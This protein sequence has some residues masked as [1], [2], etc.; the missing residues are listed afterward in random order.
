MRLKIEYK[1]LV[2][3]SFIILTLTIHIF[4]IYSKAQTTERLHLN[5][6]GFCDIEVGYDVRVGG[7]Y[8]YVT[9]NDG[10]MIINISNPS[11]PE[12]IGE[13][14]SGGAIGVSVESNLVYIASVTNGL[15]IADVSD[16][17][18]P[19]I[20]GQYTAGG[21]AYRVTISG[22]YAYVCYFDNGFKILNISD[23]TDPVHVG[24]FSDTRSDALEV[25]GNYAYLAN[26]EV[27]LKV[28][29][30]SY[31]NTP[32]H[33]ATIPQT[34]GAND[35]YITEDLLF[36]ACWGAG[37]RVIN[38]SNPISPQILD[39]YNDN[40]GGEELGLVEKDGLLYVAD[41]YGIEL[42]N[43]SDP[44]SIVEIAERRSDV[45]AA[46]D[47][48]VDDNYIYVAQGGGLLILKLSLVA[49]NGS[50]DFL[51]YLIIIFVIVVV[52]T[53]I[54]SIV[55]LKIFRPRRGIQKET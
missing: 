4:S 13:I 50:S 54:S 20:I 30:I 27:G 31:P 1:K 41:N 38:I 33:V 2:V 19:E 53:A 6:V 44:S 52:I 10:L 7:D 9:N 45:S 26:A 17:T 16:P 48:D 8:A 40:D 28:I 12:V 11:K 43:V 55:Y 37:V 49:E 23:T 42:F 15:I 46:H 39:S 25:K 5:R 32:N 35:I 3:I 14:L 18:D 34:G 51:F 24:E 29:D 21:G 36:L 47:I 22:I